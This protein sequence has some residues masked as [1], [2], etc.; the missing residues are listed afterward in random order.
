[1]FKYAGSSNEIADAQ[2]DSKKRIREF[3]NSQLLEHKKQLIRKM[4]S[5]SS[6][7][8]TEP[9]TNLTKNK[10]PDLQETERLMKIEKER[11]DRLIGQLKAAEARNR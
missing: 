5:S 10:K 3:Y 4:E 7:Y 11:H 8:S 1:M 2:S 9:M 6:I